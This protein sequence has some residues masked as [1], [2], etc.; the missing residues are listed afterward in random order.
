MQGGHLYKGN[1]EIVGIGNI[2]Q[3]GLEVEKK[4]YY[5]F[6]Y[7]SILTVACFEGTT[8]SKINVTLAIFSCRMYGV[9]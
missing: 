6:E 4:H 9:F 3:Q 7:F 1:E 2:G 5:V 8:R